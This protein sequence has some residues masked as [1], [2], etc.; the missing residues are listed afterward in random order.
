MSEKL[1]GIMSRKIKNTEIIFK[2]QN[3][4]GKKF[5]SKIKDKNKKEDISGVVLYI[6]SIV[7]TVVNVILVK[8]VAS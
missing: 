8:Q 6:K 1:K 3:S 7:M 2:S 4:I 5:F